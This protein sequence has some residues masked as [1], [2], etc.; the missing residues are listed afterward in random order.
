MADTLGAFIIMILMAGLVV[1]LAKYRAEILG[2][3]NK[4]P[5]KYPGDRAMRDFD[6]LIDHGISEEEA[7]EKIRGYR[8]HRK[9]IQ[10]AIANEPDE[11]KK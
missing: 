3:L 10:A 11:P 6:T 4:S 7:I 8:I 9:K 2:W 5:D 1:F